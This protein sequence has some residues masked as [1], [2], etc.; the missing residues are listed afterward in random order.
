MVGWERVIE[1][2]GFHPT[3][4]RDGRR[5]NGRDACC[6]TKAPLSLVGRC[7]TDELRS[8][9]PKNGANT[10]KENGLPVAVR[11][12]RVT[13]EAAG[14]RR[15]QRFRFEVT[16]HFDRTDSLPESFSSQ[17]VFRNKP[18]RRRQKEDNQTVMAGPR[19]CS[20]IARLQD[21]RPSA[22]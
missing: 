18:Y 16:L 21:F 4:G 7:K 13:V 12:N 11:C 5:A 1:Y 10:T 19:G 20:V 15:M 2:C 22:K 9:S 6:V 14:E 3:R 17:V 8:K